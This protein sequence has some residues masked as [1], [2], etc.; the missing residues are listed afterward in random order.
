M[1]GTV[2]VA[3]IYNNTTS[4]GNAYGVC[5]MFVTFF[6]TCMVTLVTLIVW[7]KPW[8]VVAVPALAIACM[9][10]AFL[11]SSL[12]KVPDGAWF[13]ITLA[14]VLAGV[15]ILWRFGKEQQWN[16]EAKDRL[17]LS[18]FVN[19]ID[20][21]LRLKQFNNEE[22]SRS[23]GFAIFF[24]KVGDKTPIVFSQFMEKLVVL[25]EV[26]VFLNIRA[27][28]APTVPDDE[29]YFVTRMKLANC[30]RLVIRHGF[31]DV[32]IT[33]D[34]S[35]VV[36]QQ[37]LR[38]ITQKEIDRSAPVLLASEQ[39]PTS[40]DLPPTPHDEKINGPSH[41]LDESARINADTAYLDAA[42]NARVLY[43]VGKEDM[44]VDK[45]SP[46]WRRVLLWAFLFIRYNTRNK[47]ASLNVPTQRL[48]EIGFVKEI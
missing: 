48:V 4:L 7:R 38:F 17:P 44:F 45:K 40:S 15:F 34:L 2:L 33:P 25:P 5:V 36:Y 16:A 37:I 1:I 19:E 43:V 28:E 3:A 29:R 47:M 10:G 22:I 42:Y 11:S 35:Q 31:M 20:G 24:D 41:N 26:M 21:S 8:W 6:D 46:I 9:D 14:A 12:T 32:V 27:V 13:T 18:M 30:Y 23:K 39:T